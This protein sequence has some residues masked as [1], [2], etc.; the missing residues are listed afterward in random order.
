MA[1][2]VRPTAACPSS[3]VPPKPGAKKPL[4]SIAEGPL[5]RSHF[6]AVN[7][8]FPTET[9]LTGVATTM[10]F[11]NFAA[12][13]GP[14]IRM[15]WPFTAGGDPACERTQTAVPRTKSTTLFT[16]S[17]LTKITR[18]RSLSPRKQGACRLEGVGRSELKPSLTLG[19]T[20]PQI[21]S[22][23][24]NLLLPAGAGRPASDHHHSPGHV[25]CLHSASP[26]NCLT[27]SR[28]FSAK[29]ESSIIPCP[30]PPVQP[31]LS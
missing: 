18:F 26:S 20:G 19:A 6:S 11:A 4:I 15:G 23:G 2:T 22:Q 17:L 16:C 7:D 27:R 13:A 30:V 8:H 21:S 10:H 25:G 3:E 29:Q 31:S 14:A 12:S 28:V 9:G 1:R 24:G 5:P